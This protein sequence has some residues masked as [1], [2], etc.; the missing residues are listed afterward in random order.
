LINWSFSVL[1]EAQ[2]QGATV[3]MPRVLVCVVVAS[4]AAAEEKPSAAERPTESLFLP[5]ARVLQHPRCM[6]CHPQ[7][8]AP[9]QFDTSK[10][11]RQNVTRK[12]ESLG[13]QC[14]SCH[15]EVAMPGA[16]QP[17]AAP[18]WRMPPA[19]VPMVFEGKTSK[20]LCEQLKDKKLNGNRSLKDIR[21]HLEKDAIVKWGFAPGEG[22]TLPPLT[23]AQLMKQVD[24]WISA[25]AQC[26][27]E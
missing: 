24:A 4:I 7:N 15:A 19:E 8:D 12:I 22:R 13:M 25:G 6:N 23:H 14:N 16:H 1:N 9:L 27:K 11:H 10:P 21:E 18:H 26:P 5:I 20:Q 17:P 3:T 2:L